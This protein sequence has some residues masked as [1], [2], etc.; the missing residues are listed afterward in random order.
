MHS[1]KYT[2]VMYTYF[3]VT[4]SVIANCPEGLYR[5]DDGRCIDRSINSCDPTTTIS[6]CITCLIQSVK[7]TT[8]GL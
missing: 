7:N 2:N 6:K 8:K 5:C 3:K 4:F 1:Y